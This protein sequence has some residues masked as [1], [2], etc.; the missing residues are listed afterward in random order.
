MSEILSWDS[1]T[2]EEN[3]PPEYNPLDLVARLKEVDWSKSPKSAT[4]RHLFMNEHIRT[5]EVVDPRTGLPYHLSSNQK[6]LDLDEQL[7]RDGIIP[8]Y[9]HRIHN[10]GWVPSPLLASDNSAWGT[11]YLISLSA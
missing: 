7:W 1:E 11:S 9:G 6:L 5:A 4:V 2:G 3:F 8:G 10:L